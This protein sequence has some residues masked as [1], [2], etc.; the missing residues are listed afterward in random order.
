[1]RCRLLLGFLALAASAE[2]LPLGRITDSVKCAADPSE[3]YALYVPSNYSPNRTWSVIFALD[4]A[5]R[6]RV[7]V[8]RYQAA[9]E[10]YGYIVAG[11]NTS[12]NGSMSASLVAVQAMVVD[13]SKRYAVESKRVYLTGLSGGARV[14]MQ[15]ALMSG[16]QIAGVIASSAGF[17]SGDPRKS[18]PFAIFG[19]AGTE[20]FNYL[21]MRQ[22]DAAVTSPH[23][24]AIFEGGHAWPPSETA[25]EAVEWME[26]QAMK[27]GRRTRDESLSDAIFARR[28]QHAEAQ[29]NDLSLCLALESLAADFEGLRDVTAFAARAAEL[30]RQKNV[31]DAMKKDRAEAQREERMLTELVELEYGL[32]EP[33]SRANS[34]SQ[35]RGRLANLA[36]QSNTAED[37]PDR[38]MARRILRG[39]FARSRD[40]MNDPEYQKLFADMRTRLN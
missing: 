5:A 11:S 7:P 9:A 4:P 13:V 23:R 1:M 16:N 25:V 24:L 36:K 26:M 37:S 12:R 17:P 8:E 34:L 2:D 31:I 38:R 14:A 3:S 33:A 32:A 20:D 10:K 6:G 21:E 27:A 15:V 28:R 22:L 30:R 19:T 18:V 40:L 35:L 29:S 39:T